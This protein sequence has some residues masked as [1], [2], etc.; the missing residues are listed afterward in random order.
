MGV[1]PGWL[2]Y[3]IDGWGRRVVDQKC[4]TERWDSGIIVHPSSQGTEGNSVLVAHPALSLVR[5]HGWYTNT[6]TW[7][8]KTYRNMVENGRIGGSTAANS[9]HSG[10]QWTPL[11]IF[12]DVQY[13]EGRW[14]RCS[15]RA[16]NVHSESHAVPWCIRHEIT[17]SA[18]EERAPTKYSRI[19]A[20]LSVAC[21]VASQFVGPHLVGISV[22][23]LLNAAV[24]LAK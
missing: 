7:L 9:E 15:A 2:K 4:V 1:S 23:N 18:R 21:A 8:R 6:S 22:D 5:Q 20:L 17:I 19:Y 10:A 24:V 11:I 13:E 3:R 16:N 14:K 12:G